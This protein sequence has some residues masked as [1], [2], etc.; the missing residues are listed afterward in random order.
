MRQVIHI[1]FVSPWAFIGFET[2]SH[3]AAEYSFRHSSMFRILVAAVSVTTALYIFVILLSVSA[4][5]EGCSGWLDY[6]KHL[7]RYEGIP[8]LKSRLTAL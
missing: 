4:Y 2:V 6:I 3:S 8:L 5:P 1:A 7:D